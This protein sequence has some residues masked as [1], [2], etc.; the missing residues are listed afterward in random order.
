MSSSP[1]AWLRHPIGL[2]GAALATFSGAV[3]VTLL[4]A[5]LAGYGGNPYL[6]MVVYVVFPALLVL[7]LVLV[8]AGAWLERRRLARLAASGGTRPTLPVVDL[9]SPRSRRRG[10]ALI[11][12]GAVALLL[13]GAFSHRGL[14][15]L[16]TPAFCGSCHSVM[17][18][19]ATLH[20][21]SAHARVNCAECHQITGSGW[22][23]RSK[24]FGPARLGS[25]LFGLDRS[26]I[27]APIRSLRP[28]R[29]TCERCHWPSKF[30]GDRLKV[31]TRHADDAASTPLKTVLLFHV[32]GAQGLTSRGIHWHVD[33]GV[34]LRYQADEK[35]ES[36]AA[37]ELTLADGRQRRWLRDGAE[38][39]SG[40]RG[41]WYEMDCIDCHNR[42]AHAFQT[43]E[44]EVDAALV[45]GR[46][47][48]KLPF[49]RREAI[50]AL[51]VEFSSREAAAAGLQAALRDFYARN[52]PAAGVE[53]DGLIDS[54]VL[55]LTAIWARNVW[56]RMKITWGAYPSLLG[57]QQEGG[58]FRCHDGR[59]ATREG[60]DVS[61][62]CNL[63]HTVLARDEKDPAILKQ[64]TR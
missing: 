39:G 27:P 20:A 11:A 29:E 59:H 30:V 26:P 61:H 21:R 55:E 9:N 41:A 7:G 40:A 2:A 13:L 42:P 5:S 64:L 25:V 50:Q 57:H 45:S 43:R 63:C 34:K 58:C 38:A 60:R 19:E 37:V 17:D 12:L 18:P 49:I 44:D 32:G 6:G 52:P 62:A 51:G 46:L 54:A 10:L 47:D 24:L 1:R 22:F 14:E 56:P 8:R 31:V 3:V 35:R 28:L 53:A 33:K 48:P 15:V 36:I 23:E 16:D 4:V